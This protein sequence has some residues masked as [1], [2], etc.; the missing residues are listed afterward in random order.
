MDI[1]YKKIEEFVREAGNI[2]LE[3]DFSRD[4]VH[5]KHGDANFCTDY[6]V[7]IQK[8]LIEHLSHIYILI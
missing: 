2:M 6:D 5:S 1:N 4:I 8:F 3:A 7:A